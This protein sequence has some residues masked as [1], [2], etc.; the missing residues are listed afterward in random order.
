MYFVPLYRIYKVVNFVKG[1]GFY[2]GII[3]ILMTEFLQ[4]EI[5]F[6][7]IFRVILRIFLFI[8]EKISKVFYV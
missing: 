3:R 7:Y 4:K 5:S 2:M 8:Q 6:I 1:D